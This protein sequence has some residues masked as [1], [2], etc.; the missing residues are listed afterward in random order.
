ME[1]KNF[2]ITIECLNEDKFKNGLGEDEKK[3]YE[4]LETIEAN[5]VF[6]ATE[7]KQLCQVSASPADTFSALE[8]AKEL[9]ERLREKH[10]ELKLME[11][12]KE[13]LFDKKSE[14]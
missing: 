12:I 9:T 7:S 5:V 11:L 14:E 10:P 1:S 6:I 13:K 8:N 2:R 3:L 4:K